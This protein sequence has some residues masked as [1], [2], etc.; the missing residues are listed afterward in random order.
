M[1]QIISAQTETHYQIAREL[2]LQYADSLDFNLEF[3]GF[4]QELAGLPGCYAPPR[5]CILLAELSGQFVGCAA[6]RPLAAKICEMKRLFV[7]PECR[8]RGIGRSLACAV[9]DRARESGYEKM[10]LDT[11][12]SMTEAKALYASLQFRSIAAY[13]YNPI[14]NTSYMELDL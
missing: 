3:Q 13:R 11:V 4:T 7:K 1:F 14:D 2:F 8:G 12:A 10:R 9:I 5:G 6:V